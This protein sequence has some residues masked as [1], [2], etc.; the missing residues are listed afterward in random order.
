M[1]QQQFNAGKREALSVIL[2]EDTAGKRAPMGAVAKKDQQNQA[3]GTLGLKCLRY[4]DSGQG[5][6]LTSTAGDADGVG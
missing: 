2:A 1:S 4:A 3:Q 6:A 5:Q